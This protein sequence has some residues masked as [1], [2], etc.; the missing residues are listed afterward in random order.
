MDQSISFLDDESFMIYQKPMARTGETW[1]FEFRTNEAFGTLLNNIAT[2]TRHDFMAL[3][4]VESKLRLLVGKGSNA[5]ELIP[6]RF[7]SDG[8]W[9]NLTLTYSPTSV[10]IAVDDTLNSASFANGSSQY[11]E[12]EET[13]YLG[14]FDV[15]KRK[16]GSNKGL[17][18]TESSLKGCM[19]NIF[20]DRTQ[21]GFPN[22][23]VTHGVAVECL[24]KYPCIEKQPCILSST[25]QQNGIEDFIC[26]CDQAYCIRADYLD[27]YK[28]FSRS[29]L[30]DEV[31]LLSISP[32]PVMEGD[33]VFLSQN[34]ID[35]IFDFRKIGIQDSGVLFHI[36]Q[37]PKYGKVTTLP[38][39]TDDT[40]NQT[41]VK[42][43]SLI[44][45][46]TDKVSMGE[47]LPI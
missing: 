31:E 42:F 38:V 30:P 5:V 39:G 1:Q 11:I 41:Q 46:S 28:I 45:L 10:E 24:W 2:S 32:M 25:C 33:S 36:I 4:I 17:Q 35:V 6:D 37:P 43:F 13:F 19:K 12:L 27:L 16:R 44:D 3:E 7:I 47:E 26:Y 21:I 23:K 22:V 14:G 20:V 40:S 29:D 34:F 8:Q 15:R 9:H 18:A